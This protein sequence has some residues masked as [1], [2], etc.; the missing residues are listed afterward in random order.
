MKSSH[1]PP[2]K[3]NVLLHLT[4]FYCFIPQSANGNDFKILIPLKTIPQAIDM[5]IHGSFIAFAIHIPYLIHQ[6]SACKYFTRIREQLEDKQKF[7]LRKLLKSILH[8][9]TAGSAKLTT[10]TKASLTLFTCLRVNVKS[11]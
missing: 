10:I 9:A 8:T 6:L 1:S 7:L 5:Y 3:H 11:P 2:S 4:V